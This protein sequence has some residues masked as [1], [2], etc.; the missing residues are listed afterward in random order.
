[1][2]TYI[3]KSAQ[4]LVDQ[5]VSSLKTLP[6]TSNRAKALNHILDS[7]EENLSFLLKKDVEDWIEKGLPSEEALKKT[8]MNFFR[9]WMT[10]AVQVDRGLGSINVAGLVSTISQAVTMATKSAMSIY[11]TVSATK[12][13]QWL[14]ERQRADESYGLLAQRTQEEIQ[15]EAIRAQQDEL[16]R[17]QEQSRKIESARDQAI[18]RMQSV[19]G[20]TPYLPYIVSIGGL[21]MVVLGFYIYK[22][23]KKRG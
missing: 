6:D 18:E 10:Q 14:A 13:R 2:E 4:R 12:Q 17:I 23:K 16:A 5:V 1:M 21:A 8:L 15:L 3:E 20:E 19:G 7:L 22:K 9:S 11:S